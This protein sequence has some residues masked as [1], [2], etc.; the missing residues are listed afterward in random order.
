MHMS[1]MQFQTNI[2]FSQSFPKEEKARIY[3]NSENKSISLVA[4][5]PWLRISVSL[6]EL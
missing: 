2:I 1:I 6:V 3:K 5:F 4:Y